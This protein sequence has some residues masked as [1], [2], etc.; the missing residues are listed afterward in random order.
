MFFVPE[1]HEH[2]SG[3]KGNLSLQRLEILSR[4]VWRVIEI[5]IEE[6]WINERNTT[7]MTSRTLK[8]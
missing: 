8:K 2:D 1:R 7:M 4:G 6:S 5:D 3:S